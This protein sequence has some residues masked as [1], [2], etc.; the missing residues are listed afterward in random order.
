MLGG[1]PGA[2]KSSSQYY[3][4]HTILGGNAIF[5]SLDDFRD[6]HPH[7][8]EI[9]KLHR[10]KASI[11]T[12]EFASAIT[13]IIYQKAIDG[14]Y[15]FVLESTFRNYDN[16][17]SRLDMLHNQHKYTCNI[18]VATCPRD[19]S[20][21]GTKIRVEDARRMGKP[22][23]GVSTDIHDLAVKVLAENTQ[24]LFENCKYDNFMIRSRA[25]DLYSNKKSECKNITPSEVI[26]CEL[27][28]VLT[29]DEIEYV[30]MARHYIR[31]SNDLER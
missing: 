17:A 29:K 2:G 20:Y 22:L 28:R 31:R 11:Y 4:I 3:I 26:Q 15:N 27:I 7:A 23:R 10:E 12:H 18:V 16:I 8:E 6:S 19:V 25:G 5:I 21:A 14:R 24:K 9:Q 1:Q 30:K 13:N